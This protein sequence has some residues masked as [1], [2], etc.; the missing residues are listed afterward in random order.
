MNGLYIGLI[1]YL[2]IVSE[3]ICAWNDNFLFPEQM[4]RRGL[5]HGI[6]LAAHGGIW[7]DW[8]IITPMIV[9]ITQAYSSQ[10]SLTQISAMLS[11]SAMVT[12]SMCLMWIHLGK[13]TPESLSHNGLLTLAGFIHAIYMIIALT[14]ILLFFFYSNIALWHMIIIAIILGFHIIIGNHII[15]SLVSPP[16]YKGKNHRDLSVWSQ[17]AVIWI[18][19]AWRCFIY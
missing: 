13:T 14:I 2:L 3:I 18:L 12:I 4:I 16:W 1:G 5:K 11:V 15:L 9:I 19:M 17:L 7:G 10:W 6:P 8:L